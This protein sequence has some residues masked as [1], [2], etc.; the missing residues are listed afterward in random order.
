MSI[1]QSRKKGA[2]CRNRRVVHV[3]E[4]LH[5]P[6]YD[7]EGDD[8]LAWSSFE[9]MDKDAM[10]FWNICDHDS[11]NAWAE[12][13]DN[14]IQN[15][16]IPQYNKVVNIGKGYYQDAPFPVSVSDRLDRIQEFIESWEN[17]GIS[18]NKKWYD[19]FKHPVQPYWYGEIRGIITYFDD[20]ACYVDEL[21]NICANDFKRPSCAT[22]PPKWTLEPAP[23]ASGSYLDGSGGPSPGNG[24]PG[25]S[26]LSTAV[27]IMAIGAA[28]YFG[29]KVLTE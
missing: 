14:Y 9:L 6:H 29:F 11:Y 25:K 27:G 3:D 28:G 2:N 23:T 15:T 13:T 21:N 16:L 19:D 8:G 18:P 10:C 26:G 7:W 1:W 5:S 4:R 24:K 17:S 20:A 12:A 22:T